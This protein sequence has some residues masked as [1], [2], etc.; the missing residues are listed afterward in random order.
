MRRKSQPPYPSNYNY[1]S[2]YKI[3]KDNK[4]VKK[5][6]TDRILKEYNSKSDV[7]LIEIL[8]SMGML[9]QPRRDAIKTILDKR[10]KTTIRYLTEVIQKN[11]KI[12]EKYNQTLIKLTYFIAL[13]TLLMIIGLIIQTWLVI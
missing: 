13:L 3:D 12:S 4:M 5:E 9:T 8:G 11:S 1:T 7:E 10:T 6:F 2:V